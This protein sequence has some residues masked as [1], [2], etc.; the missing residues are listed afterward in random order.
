M[1]LKGTQLLG[2]GFFFFLLQNSLVWINDEILL[3]ISFAIFYVFCYEQLKASLND[4][5]LERRNSFQNSPFIFLKKLALSDLRK[6]KEYQLYKNLTLANM[7]IHSL[8]QNATLIDFANKNIKETKKNIFEKKCLDVLSFEE[9]YKSE[10]VNF[11]T[12]CLMEETFETPLYKQKHYTKQ[13]LANQL[14]VLRSEI[15][16]GK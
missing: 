9:S 1:K 8:D 2:F 5:F 7:V 13:F 10:M 11:L 14:A 3:V 6:Q 16:T 15:S 4:F 12:E